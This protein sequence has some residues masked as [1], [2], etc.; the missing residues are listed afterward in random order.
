MQ[1]VPNK[2]RVC[3]YPQIPCKPFIVEV[4]DEEQAFLV[5][6]V[7][8]NQHNFLFE[9]RMI[10]DYSNAITVEMLDDVDGD[11]NFDWCDYFNEQEQMEWDELVETYLQIPA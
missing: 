3:H 8:A 7:M 11:G 4:K 9:N 2:L 5:A 6:E 10:P 1:N